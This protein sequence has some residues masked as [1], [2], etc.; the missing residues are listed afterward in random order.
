VGIATEDP[1]SEFL[2]HTRGS[3]AI[4]GA[5]PAISGA[6]RPCPGRR[7]VATL[8]TRWSASPLR[9]I[10]IGADALRR[11]AA[12]TLRASPTVDDAKRSRRVRGRTAAWRSSRRDTSLTHTGHVLKQSTCGISCGYASKASGLCGHIWPQKILLDPCALPGHARLWQANVKPI[13]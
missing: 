1:A 8:A 2:G 4:S 3:P 13:N 5:V 12:S 9:P 7:A 11:P 10:R 6:V